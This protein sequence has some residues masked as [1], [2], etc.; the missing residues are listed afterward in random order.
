MASRLKAGGTQMTENPR[1]LRK[2]RNQ[3]VQGG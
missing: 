2:T 3:L 1:N